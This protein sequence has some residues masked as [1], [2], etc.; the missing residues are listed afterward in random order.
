MSAINSKSGLGNDMTGRYIAACILACV[1]WM[2][3]VGAR[4]LAT[5]LLATSWRDLQFT[6]RQFSL[7]TLG[8]TAASLVTA[9]PAGLFAD[10]V[11]RKSLVVSSLILA[12]VAGVL[13]FM[14]QG[15]SAWIAAAFVDGVAAAFMFTAIVAMIGRLPIMGRGAIVGLGLSGG[16]I[17]TSIGAMLTGLFAHSNT[18]SVALGFAIAE[19]IVAILFVVF[20]KDA[21]HHAAVLVGDGGLMPESAMSQIVVA[22]VVLLT[23]ATG[24][25]AFGPSLVM[26]LYELNTTELAYGFG[27]WMTRMVLQLAVVGALVA[28]WFCRRDLRII[29]WLIAVAACVMALSIWLGTHASTGS[30]SIFGF[31]LVRGGAMF[32]QGAI[33]TVLACALAPGSRGLFAGIYLTLLVL[34]QLM[35]PIMVGM[36]SDQFRDMGAGEGLRTAVQMSIGFTIWALLHLALARHTIIKALKKL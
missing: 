29:P 24:V 10:R 6:D 35:G 12:S 33:L 9:V 23:L 8:A 17:F 13:R 31:M 15:A 22:S 30:Q 18:R 34:G 27:Y 21:K 36:L 3:M 32:V 16:I 11:S 19:I 5:S 26:R 7:V 4:G 2:L 1:G 20:G 25:S 14:A 28:A